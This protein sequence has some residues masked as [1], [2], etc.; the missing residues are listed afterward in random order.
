M[1][2]VGAGP[3]E[4]FNTSLAYSKLAPARP[5][6]R[7]GWQGWRRRRRRRGWRRRRRAAASF[8]P[9]RQPRRHPRPY[10]RL[11]VPAPARR[12]GGRR[13]LGRG[14][15]ERRR[16]R[17]GAAVGVA[18]G[19]EGGGFRAGRRG[20][21]CGQGVRCGASSPRQGSRGVAAETIFF[22]IYLVHAKEIRRARMFRAV[23][24]R[25]G[26]LAVGSSVCLQPS[27]LSCCL[28]CIRV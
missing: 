5:G 2:A 8:E 12:R 17:R 25:F 9:L 7:Q 3:A 6:R 1:S 19:R 22:L 11:A 10:S 18:G 16:R 14:R 26:T 27:V 4:G 13:L 28:H 24:V 15:R 21:G 23:V 20:G